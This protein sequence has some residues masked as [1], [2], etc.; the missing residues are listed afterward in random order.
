MIPFLTKKLPFC[1]LFCL[2]MGESMAQL[3]VL[4][5]PTPEIAAA[6]RAW[7][8]VRND[9]TNWKNV[10]DIFYKLKAAYDPYFVS[11]YAKYGFEYQN[12]SLKKKDND[13]II[14][15]I[16]SLKTIS[17]YDTYP[18]QL[19]KATVNSQNQYVINGYSGLI[20]HLWRVKNLDQLNPL[21]LNRSIQAVCAARKR[22]GDTTTGHFIKAST[23]L[24][25]NYKTYFDDYT[26]C[27]TILEAILPIAQMKYKNL[28][29]GKIKS[30]TL[31][32][33]FYLMTD[34]QDAAADL[35][36][37]DVLT[38]LSDAYVKLGKWEKAAFNYKQSIILYRNAQSLVIADDTARF[39]IVP[40]STVTGHRK[41]FVKP[42]A[43]LNEAI[44]TTHFIELLVKQ[45]RFKEASLVI[46]EFSKRMPKW[47]QDCK[48]PNII[49][50]LN[51]T[52][53]QI[54]QLK[55]QD[56]AFAKGDFATVKK[57][58]KQFEASEV[59][60][61]TYTF[62]H[63]VIL[64]QFEKALKMN[65]TLLKQQEAAKS[66]S[67]VS[68][69]LTQSKL[70]MLIGDRSQSKKMLDKVSLLVC[71]NKELYP[72]KEAELLD[73]YAIIASK[74]GQHIQSLSYRQQV[75]ALQKAVLPP[76]S[77]AM[78]RA[79]SS[80]A[81]NY[82]LFGMLDSAKYYYDKT[83]RIHDS[84]IGKQ[85]RDYSWN[86][87]QLSKIAYQKKNYPLAE[88]IAHQAVDIIQDGAK[89]SP[90]DA[91]SIYQGMVPI[92]LANRKIEEAR[93]YQKKAWNMRWNQ[94]KDSTES[95]LLE[96]YRYNI[97][98][99]ENQ[100]NPNPNAQ[101]I[102]NWLQLMRRVM[103][104]NFE[105]LS[106]N[107]K[108]QFMEALNQEFG[109]LSS[110][111][112]RNKLKNAPEA[113]YDMALL[114]K[115]IVLSDSKGF[116]KRMWA[117]RETDSI[118]FQKAF[119]LFGMMKTLNNE[120][121]DLSERAKF[122][123]E[124]DS[125]RT[126]LNK[127][128]PEL[129]QTDWDK[130]NWQ[131]VQKQL[132]E[133]EVAIEIIDFQ[134]HTPTVPT[135]SIVYYAAVLRKGD[136]QPTM[137][138]LFEEKQLLKYL[139]RSPYVKDEQHAENLYITHSAELYDLIWKPFEKA[140]LLKQGNTV[141][142]SASGQLN[143]VA[144]GALINGERSTSKSILFRDLY[145]L[146]MVNSTREIHVDANDK[147]LRTN[148]LS[149]LLV[150]GVRYEADSTAIVEA[151]KPQ[152]K[153]T[154]HPKV[155]AMRSLTPDMDGCGWDY[156][157]GSLTEVQAIHAAIKTQ[158]R[159]DAT[160]LTGF[161]ASEDNVRAQLKSAPTI[162]HLSTHGEY[163]LPEHRNLTPMQALHNNFILLAGCKRKCEGKP[164]IEGMEDGVLTAAEVA[165]MDLKK[166]QLV[167]LSACKTGL[168]DL[169]G[170]EGV[171]GLARGFKLAGAKYQLV[172]LWQVPDVATAPFMQLFYQKCLNG[173][174]IQDAFLETQA[175]LRTQYPDAPYK[176]A[177]WVLIR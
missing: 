130:T 11:E 5:A 122:S 172:S 173:T 166:T 43:L 133:N 1:L 27:V 151:L 164:D 144:L 17:Q 30:D 121:I 55:I 49:K 163:T 113:F 152:Q 16:D 167:V 175:V 37:A 131:D 162:L 63:L 145:R 6:E 73:Y 45:A 77:I 90:V 148:D 20:S 120:N 40:S 26:K 159:V 46:D 47:K 137:L 51:M 74:N 32:N 158:K 117:L 36:L 94:I 171:F 58:I 108:T 83:L 135:D 8:A 127:T 112:S 9:T 75:L 31:Q 101:N 97:Q 123:V 91:F 70:F 125:L 147:V 111:L 124:A 62:S 92:L 109:I 53:R 128:T 12:T 142:V 61:S 157:N 39:K 42:I 65:T 19:L 126:I 140:S 2:F 28:L 44:T 114:Q 132:K 153:L 100:R 99:T 81:D 35:L 107:E 85:H 169:R 105:G 23:D 22:F 134:Y 161:S 24:A 14:R 146:E 33:D 104:T 168:G 116:Q 56:I 3:P 88:S 176:W 18:I 154:N 13:R 66:A 52:Y 174:T 79:Y 150:G 96:N 68:T 4:P 59:Y 136:A 41:E 118:A 34:T 72:N 95:K 139:Q 38:T 50:I 54:W 177:A 103:K 102:Q 21:A 160:L 76:I 93:L 170:R 60:D 67:V 7:L 86:L 141:Y 106:D 143:R 129:F 69:L 87:K 98:I 115:S 25:S 138:R 71:Q 156:L 80:L 165:D 57:C 78:A 149:A 10:F 155:S 48:D 84:I 64:G 110:I 29:E 89:Y 15:K 119:Q 82:L